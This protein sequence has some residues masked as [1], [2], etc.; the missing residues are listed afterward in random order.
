MVELEE[1]T[2]R[3]TVENAVSGRYIPFCYVFTSVV[4]EM[5]RINVRGP[6]P[7]T[8]FDVSPKYS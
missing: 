7:L 5:S 3:P 2:A 4:V 1:V 6:I 8:V